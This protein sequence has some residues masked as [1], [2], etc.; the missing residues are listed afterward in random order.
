MLKRS[1]I[2]WNS[3]GSFLLIST[4]ALRAAELDL[5]QESGRKSSSQIFELR[6]DRKVR[7]TRWIWRHPNQRK[8]LRARLPSP[9]SPS[10]ERCI[11]PIRPG[12]VH[13]QLQIQPRMDHCQN[14]VCID[15][16]QLER[17]TTRWN[18]GDWPCSTEGN[19]ISHC[20]QDF[21]FFFWTVCRFYLWIQEWINT[22]HKS[23]SADNRMD[24]CR[25]ILQAQ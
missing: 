12:I 17:T 25:I 4:A 7:L 6:F 24:S 19:G 10:R 1:T 16:I 2:C 15:W 18:A 11:R 3:T 8:R 23:F 20:W 22:N 9:L 14:S 21:W 13:C 5:N